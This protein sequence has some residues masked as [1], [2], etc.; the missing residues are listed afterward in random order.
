MKIYAQNRLES[1]LRI[2]CRMHKIKAFIRSIRRAELIYFS[3]KP[4]SFHF[5]PNGKMVI[6]NGHGYPSS[7]LL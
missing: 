7:N 4:F 5:S 3:D 1:L 2:H 6:G